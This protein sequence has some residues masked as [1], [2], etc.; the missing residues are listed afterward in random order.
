TGQG[1]EKKR[2]GTRERATSPN[3]PPINDAFGRRTNP[4]LKTAHARPVRP[5]AD[6]GPRIPIPSV[7]RRSCVAVHRRTWIGIQRLDPSFFRKSTLKRGD[8][9]GFYRRY[10]PTGRRTSRLSL[11]S[12]F[13]EASSGRVD[14]LRGARGENVRN[15]LPKSF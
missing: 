9:R 6:E 11:G 3:A 13:L 2:S 4:F 5:N 7:S 10:T 15:H 14:S 8:A 12:L 1:M